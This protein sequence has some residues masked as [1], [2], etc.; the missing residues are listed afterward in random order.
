MEYYSCS[1]Q[2][3]KTRIIYLEQDGNLK[4]PQSQKV[5]RGTKILIHIPIKQQIIHIHLE[6]ACLVD[7][8]LQQ[9]S[10]NDLKINVIT[11]LNLC[12]IPVYN[13]DYR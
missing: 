10:I 11:N 2:L 7:K 6:G 3:T 4:H 13:S 12:S 8:K 9:V 1:L 5:F